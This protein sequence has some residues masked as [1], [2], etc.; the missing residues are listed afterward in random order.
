MFHF[1]SAGLSTT[2]FGRAKE[3]TRLNTW[4]CPPTHMSKHRRTDTA[5]YALYAGGYV[6]VC[7]QWIQ[8]PA[9]PKA[10]PEFTVTCDYMRLVDPLKK[11][12]GFAASRLSHLFEN[13]SI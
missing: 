1:V 10:A 9:E 3:R 4:Y 13:F 2:H 6:I 11:R 5:V 7:A 12:S 8:A